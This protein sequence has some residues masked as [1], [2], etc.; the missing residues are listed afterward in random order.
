MQV[1]TSSR[2]PVKFVVS[3]SLEVIAVGQGYGGWN[4]MKAAILDHWSR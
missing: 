1:K 2:L 3:P 4:D